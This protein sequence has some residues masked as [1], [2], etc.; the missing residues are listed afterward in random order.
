[1]VEKDFYPPKITDNW[2]GR[3]KR[4]G[5]KGF[6]IL[7]KEGTHGDKSKGKKLHYNEIQGSYG[8]EQNSW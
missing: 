6:Y 3:W 1:M 4:T 2:S 5:S 8:I 7:K